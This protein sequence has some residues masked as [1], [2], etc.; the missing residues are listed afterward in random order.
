MTQ[1]DQADS[2]LGP[3]DPLTARPPAT[4]RWVKIAAIVIGLLVVALALKVIVVGGV[5]HGPGMHSGLGGASAPAAVPA[6][7]AASGPGA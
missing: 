5:S 3:T 2:T 4:P 7:S 1:P 6:A